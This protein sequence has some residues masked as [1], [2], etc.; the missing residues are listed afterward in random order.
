MDTAD[1]TDQ[2]VRQLSIGKMRGLQ[3]ISNAH[4]F[5]TMTAL[6]HRGSM[7]RM[8]APRSPEAVTTNQLTR[9][10]R[11]LTRALAPVSS[12]VLIDPIYGA[13]QVI[14]GGDLPRDTGLLVGI[15]AT[16]YN[17][18]GG[19]RLTEYLQG[20]SVEKIKRMGASA[21][22]ILLY[23]RPDLIQAAERQRALL[24]RFVEDCQRADLPALVEP[25]CYPALPGDEQAELYAQ[26]KPGIVAQTARELT[27]LGVDVLKAEFP[28]D[29]HLERD[30]AR[31]LEACQALEDA[32]SAPWILL[33]G[34]VGFEQF[35]A[36]VRVACQAGAS[37]FLAGRAVWQEAMMLPEVAERQRW[38]GT[39]AVER[40]VRLT[41]IVG[42]FGRP[43]WRKW[44]STPEQLTAVTEDWYTQF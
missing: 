10:K 41:D 6:D 19:A 34:G 33:S 22:K 44:A 12:A 28:S 4:G 38:L 7:Q 1:T 35:A 20:W 8:I 16:G 29:A 5:F 27:Q 2:R 43:W 11:D 26:R 13:A 25:L 30:E 9:Y 24:M 21:A 40:V 18:A 36:Q 31:M 42:E 14:A 37:G 17:D 32:S 15:E 23:Y 39:V 3:Q